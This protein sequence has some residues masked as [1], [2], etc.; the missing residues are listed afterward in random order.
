VVFIQLVFEFIRNYEKGLEEA[1]KA[2]NEIEFMKDSI[3]IEM[4]W[5]EQCFTFPL[6][7][8]DAANLFSV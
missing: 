2:L 5:Y 1:E 3:K 6:P 7:I 4:E 8:E